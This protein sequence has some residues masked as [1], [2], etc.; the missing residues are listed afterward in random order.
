MYAIFARDGAHPGRRP[1]RPFHAVTTP[2]AD[3]Y[4]GT[5]QSSSWHIFC[6]YSIKIYAASFP[7]YIKKEKDIYIIFSTRKNRFIFAMIIAGHAGNVMYT[8]N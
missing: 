3:K 5:G 6:Y 2:A 7:K 4:R 1:A 8:H